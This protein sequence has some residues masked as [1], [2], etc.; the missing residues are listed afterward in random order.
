MVKF[1]YSATSHQVMKNFTDAVGTGVISITILIKKGGCWRFKETG[2][3][4]HG[5]E[6]RKQMNAQES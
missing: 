1:T 2:V 6:V 3:I 4:E 5:R